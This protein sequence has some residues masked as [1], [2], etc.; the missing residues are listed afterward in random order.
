M[1]CGCVNATLVWSS[2]YISLPLSLSSSLSL[3]LSLSLSLSLS[4]TSCSL[5]L[6]PPECATVPLLHVTVPLL[7]EPALFGFMDL[8]LCR[9]VITFPEK[10]NWFCYIF[11]HCSQIRC[12][13]EIWVIIFNVSCCILI[14]VGGK[15]WK[16][17][18]FPVQCLL[19]SHSSI[20]S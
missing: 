2:L 8:P 3:F 12:L 7:W 13:W 18:T 11:C 20:W 6:A 19:S 1:K 17:Y 4:P 14:N 10:M 16:S 9:A 5:K 15:Q